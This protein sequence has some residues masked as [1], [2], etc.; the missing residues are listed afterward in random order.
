M[1]N[2]ISQA[3]RS[4][5][6]LSWMVSF[7]NMKECMIPFWRPSSSKGQLIL[8]CHFFTGRENIHSCEGC[9]CWG[10]VLLAC[11][12]CKASW[13]AQRRGPHHKCWLR[14][15]DSTTVIYGDFQSTT[16]VYSLLITII[17]DMT[18]NRA[19]GDRIIVLV[20]WY[21]ISIAKAR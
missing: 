17:S 15:I 19:K 3:L 1:V 5:A 13:E 10:W 4:Y 11:L 8:T 14:Y 20:C 9:K 6:I 12:V 21:S 2:S 18:L 16:L 7:D